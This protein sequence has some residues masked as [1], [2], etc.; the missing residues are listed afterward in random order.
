MVSNAQFRK[1]FRAENVG[2]HYSGKVHFAFIT[3]WCAVAIS[4]C[5]YFVHQPT[6]LQLLVI[7]ITFLYTNLFEYIG[8]RF[9]MHHHTKLLKAVFRRHTLQH[10]KFFTDEHMDYDNVNDF[11]IV[12]FPPVLLVFFS[13]FFVAPIFALIYHFFSL[14]AALLYV[15]T[16][17]A[18]YLN[19]E[20]LH[21]A[22]HLPATHWAYRIPGL[23]TL[24]HLHH[25]HHNLKDMTRY[26]F[27]ISYPVFDLLFGTL[28]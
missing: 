5:I 26:N 27:N 4:M 9:P 10:H 11:K 2:K 24:R 18:Y 28:K 19:Y 15:A 25:R 8:H 3:L 13:A 23:K 22:Y 6:W 7:P 20:W 12:L 14:N 1:Q 21:L 16:T 17:L